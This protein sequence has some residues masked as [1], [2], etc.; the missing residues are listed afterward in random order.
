M[1]RY[2]SYAGNNSNDLNVRTRLRNSTLTSNQEMVL[3]IKKEETKRLIRQMFQKSRQ[4]LESAIRYGEELSNLE[5]KSFGTKNQFYV[6]KAIEMNIIRIVDLLKEDNL[7]YK[8]SSRD[9][10]K[11]FDF[12][13]NYYEEKNS[14][15]LVVKDININVKKII[16]KKE[17]ILFPVISSIYSTRTTPTQEV[18]TTQDIPSKKTTSHK[19]IVK[20]ESFLFPN[21]STNSS[22]KTSLTSKVNTTEDLLLQM[23]TTSQQS[24]QTSEQEYNHTLCSPHLTPIILNNEYSA[25]PQMQTIWSPTQMDVY[26]MATVNSVKRG[27]FE[28]IFN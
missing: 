5:S 8:I 10:L 19:I 25:S 24:V 9:L 14:Q 22:I 7:L 27:I 4:Q 15:K 21:I 11:C 26:L 6:K 18:M 28:N 1:S 17:V 20:K 13:N 12:I 2:F 23:M 3:N 16:E